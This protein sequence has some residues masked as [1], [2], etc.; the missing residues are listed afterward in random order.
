MLF[1]ALV[2]EK[3]N[4]TQQMCI[5]KPKDTITLKKHKK[6]NLDLVT[7]YDIWPGNETGL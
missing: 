5:S 1:S 7:L 4:L 3:L 6:N 2:M